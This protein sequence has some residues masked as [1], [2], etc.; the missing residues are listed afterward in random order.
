MVFEQVRPGFDTLPAAVRAR[1]EDVLGSPV[2][3]VESR[4]GGFSPGTADR[5]V[6]G[7]GRRAFVKAAS[8][9]VNERTV[10]MHR[11]E[12]EVLRLLRGSGAAPL[13]IAV[14][15]EVPWIAL[16]IQDVDGRHPDP[17]AGADGTAVLDAVAALPAA[18]P[19]LGAV[20]DEL[21]GDADAWSR[22]LLDGAAPVGQDA[23]TVLDALARSAGERI[24]GASTVHLD[25]RRDNVLI[26]RGGRARIVDWPSAVRGARW[27]DGVT[28]LLDLRTAGAPSAPLESHPLLA[29]APPGSVD[30]LLALLGG[31]FFDAARRSAPPGIPGVRTAQRV[32]GEAVLGWLSER[33]PGLLT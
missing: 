12:A 13:L 6:L 26:E 1:I 30:A 29:A 28:Y 16:V 21:A 3:A 8:A 14:V 4:S 7:D 18:P 33:L 19:G 10:A 15:D 9:A 25:L 27:I 32:Q 31:Y 17:R 24:R 5:L 23:A 11:R 20:E 2:V 22:L